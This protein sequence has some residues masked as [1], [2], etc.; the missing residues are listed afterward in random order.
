MEVETAENGKFDLGNDC[1]MVLM[2]K[3]ML[4]QQGMFFGWL[5][6]MTLVKFLVGR[7]TMGVPLLWW[8]LGAVIGYVFV[9]L[10]VWLYEVI[11]NFKVAWSWRLSDL[12]KLIREVEEKETLVMRSALFIVVWLV[13]GLLTVTSVANQFSRGFVWGIGTHLMIDLVSDYMKKGVAIDWWFRQIKRQLADEEK[14]W[15]L[16]MV[17]LLYLLLAVNL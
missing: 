2:E 5:V 13:L 3:K 15:F 11:N 17:G 16:G 10:D 8:I 7:W 6:V 1:R 9:F 14:K 4:N 12:L